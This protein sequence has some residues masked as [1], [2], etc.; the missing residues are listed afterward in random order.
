[1]KPELPIKDYPDFVKNPYNN[2]VLN[3]NYA[4]L[5]ERK[6]KKEEQ[7]KVNNLSLEVTNIQSELSEIKQLLALLV[8]N[9]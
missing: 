1:M 2:A 6:R 7:E 5:A 9:K 4:A 8:N 3:T